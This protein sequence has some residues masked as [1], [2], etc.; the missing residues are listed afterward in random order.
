MTEVRITRR[1]AAPRQLVFEAWTDPEQVANWWAP[2]G[3]DYGGLA[4]EIKARLQVQY[5]VVEMTQQLDLLE[6][7]LV[8][9]TT[10][11]ED[12]EPPVPPVVARELTK[13]FER[14][15]RGTLGELAE[16]LAGV[17]VRGEATVIIDGVGKGGRE[18]HPLP[19]ANNF[20]VLSAFHR[21]VRVSRL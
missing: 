20:P 21:I 3:F 4:S 18:G 12:D 2:E 19:T 17:E 9:Q 6:Q 5:D 11:V 1:F 10:A 13:K 16:R 14:V 8:V 15:E 7:L